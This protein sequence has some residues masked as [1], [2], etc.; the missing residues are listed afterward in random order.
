MK[1]IKLRLLILLFQ[2]IHVIY[3][4]AKRVNLLHINILNIPQ[5][6]NS[7]FPLHF[8]NILGTKGNYCVLDLS[9][10]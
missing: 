4:C 7:A 8:K 10:F 5:F 9:W 3:V 2:N 1:V 6:Y